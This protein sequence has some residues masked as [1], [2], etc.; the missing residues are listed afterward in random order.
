[1]TAFKHLQEEEFQKRQFVS[2]LSSQVTENNINVPLLSLLMWGLGNPWQ[3]TFTQMREARRG[4]DKVEMM[5]LPLKKVQRNN[6]D[7]FSRT[8][9]VRELTWPQPQWPTF[10]R[11]AASQAL[12][13]PSLVFSPG[14]SWASSSCSRM[15]DIYDSHATFCLAP[16]Q[17]L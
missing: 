16:G 8:G 15:L 4:E 12:R 10:P 1:M 5:Y 13:P 7:S 6:D 3:A 14:K 17:L 11:K 2:V 9:V